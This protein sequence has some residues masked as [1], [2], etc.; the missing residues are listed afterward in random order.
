MDEVEIDASVAD[1][2][3]VELEAV[4]QEGEARYIPSF[5][6]LQK[7]L[8]MTLKALDEDGNVVP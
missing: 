2:A 5:T 1:D 7:T 6:L 8:S 4:R 3:P